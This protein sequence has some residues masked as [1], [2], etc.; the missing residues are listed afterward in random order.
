[1]FKK[2][3]WVALMTLLLATTTACSGS[4]SE[5]SSAIAQENPII[6]EKANEVLSVSEFVERA[7]N[8]KYKNGDI[9]FVSGTVV[10]T[11]ERISQTRSEQYNSITLGPETMKF[12]LLVESEGVIGGTKF[13]AGFKSYASIGKK[14]EGEEVIVRG[15]F[16]YVN[17]NGFISI[18]GAT[19]Q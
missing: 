10:K 13:E 7:L 1:M 12:V 19:A 5:S 17:P 4:L 6:Q 9:V 18:K 8:D 11:G 15:T 16:K 14:Q 2:L 3:I